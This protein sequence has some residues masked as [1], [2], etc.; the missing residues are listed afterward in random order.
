LFSAIELK[1][2]KK[3]GQSFYAKFHFS[4]AKQ[5]GMVVNIC[6]PGTQEAE[7]ADLCEFRQVCSA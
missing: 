3:L 6:N 7:K 2:S 5:P 1:K 4:K